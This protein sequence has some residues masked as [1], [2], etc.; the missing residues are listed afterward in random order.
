MT[1][2]R[3][4]TNGGTTQMKNTPLR[5]TNNIILN[6]G[7]GGFPLLIMHLIN[8]QNLINRTNN[9]AKNIILGNGI[10]KAIT[11]TNNNKL[12]GVL[13]IPDNPI[14]ALGEEF[15]VVV[16]LGGGVE[17]VQLGVLVLED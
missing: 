13:I 6:L 2:Q 11:A 3:S 8:T 7:I 12:G 1:G 5:Q 14:N 17:E 15:Y 9:I 4:H 16:G 10:T